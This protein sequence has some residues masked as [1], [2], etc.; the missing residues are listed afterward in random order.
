[1]G[2]PTAIAIGF[3]SKLCRLSADL[4]CGEECAVPFRNP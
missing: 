1:M 2:V 4:S 3:F